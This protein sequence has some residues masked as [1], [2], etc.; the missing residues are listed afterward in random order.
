MLENEPRNGIVHT[1]LLG[2]SKATASIYHKA[3]V[4]IYCPGNNVSSAE[5]PVLFC[6]MFSVFCLSHKET[7]SVVLHPIR[8]CL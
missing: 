7:L 2:K 1:Y 5:A 3:D 6:S 4:Y 8:I